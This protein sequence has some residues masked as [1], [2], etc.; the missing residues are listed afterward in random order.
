MMQTFSSNSQFFF[1]RLFLEFKIR[2]NGKK[3]KFNAV[4][5]NR[6]K[7]FTS[8]RFLF[9]TLGRSEFHLFQ[10]LRAKSVPKN[11]IDF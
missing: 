1:R 6:E 8:K 11:S 10:T 3:I 5:F 7:Y 9:P 2:R 4:Q